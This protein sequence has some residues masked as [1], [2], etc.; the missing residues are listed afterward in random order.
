MVFAEMNRFAVAAAGTT[1]RLGRGQI[2]LRNGIISAFF[3]W[4]GFVAAMGV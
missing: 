1:G 2:A 3:I 4:A